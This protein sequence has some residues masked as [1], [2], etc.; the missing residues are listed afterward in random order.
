MKRK[1]IFWGVSLI[2]IAIFI[3]VYQMG[4]ISSEISIWSIVLGILFGI[5]LIDG[6]LSLSFGGICFPL[7][8][9]WA[10]FGETIGLPHISIWILILAAL[11]L[12]IGFD[13]IFP[14]KKKKEEHW[15]KHMESMHQTFDSVDAREIHEDSTQNDGGSH[16]TCYNKFGATTKYVT[17]TNLVSATLENH[18]GEMIVY[19]DSAK[20]VGDYADVY[21]K[22]S[23]GS[24]Q[25]FI[26]REWRVENNINVTMGNV[27]EKNQSKSAGTP[28]LRLNG[29]V[30]LGDLE[31]TY[32]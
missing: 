16:V 18:F 14:R 30:S 9:L 24:V 13:T 23:F 3:V 17:T 28:V 21:V 20:I 6:I 1:N 19:F 29:D 32:I 25:L 11:L 12:T 8:F 15:R 4:M 27:E 26:P 5:A 7:A 2:A 31:I 22:A 10:L